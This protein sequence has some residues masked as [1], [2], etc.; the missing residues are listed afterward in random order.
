MGVTWATV[1]EVENA[2]G[3][4]PSAPGDVAHLDRCTAAAN[5]FGFRRRAQAG[6]VDEPDVA[7]GD[8]AV[9]GVITYAVALWRERGAVDS[10]TSFDAYAAAAVPSS[11][12]GQVLRLL[13]VGRPAVDAPRPDP[14]AAYAATLRA[15]AFVMPGDGP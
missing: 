7:P 1:G 15:R 12:F 10:F 8:D 2:L 13:G 5:A 14:A 4:P 9:L 11:T 6:Y 3:V